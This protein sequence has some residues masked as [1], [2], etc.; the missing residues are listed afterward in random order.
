MFLGIQDAQDTSLQRIPMITLLMFILY[1]IS[2]IGPGANVIESNLSGCGTAPGH[3]VF[4]F[5]GILVL[6]LVYTQ[7][8]LWAIHFYLP[9]Y[10]LFC[11]S[12]STLLLHGVIAKLMYMMTYS[13]F[14][15]FISSKVLL[16]TSLHSPL[17]LNLQRKKNVDT[18]SQPIK[19][20]ATQ[21][22]N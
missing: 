15:S 6:Y 4:I 7:F 5:Y 2:P 9:L 17:P 3:L 22:K 16:N 14:Y 8:E 11:W 13:G 10:V 21:N 19:L 12:V 20:T 1:T 18:S